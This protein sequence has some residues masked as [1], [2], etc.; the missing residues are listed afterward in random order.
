MFVGLTTHS[1][2]FSTS[3]EAHNMSGMRAAM[4][5]YNECAHIIKLRSALAGVSIC[6]WLL[7]HCR[8]LAEAPDCLPAGT[9]CTRFWALS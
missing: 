6:P 8:N 3:E 7:V 2:S 1:S 4:L 9:S 5:K